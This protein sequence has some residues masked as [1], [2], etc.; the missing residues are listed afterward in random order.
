MRAIQRRTRH[1]RPGAP[2]TA[3]DARRRVQTVH[4]GIFGLSQTDDE[5][6]EIAARVARA[7]LQRLQGKVERRGLG[8]LDKVRSRASRRP[9]SGAPL[10]A[11]TA[12]KDSRRRR[13][14][15]AQAARILVAS[16]FCHALRMAAYSAEDAFADDEYEARSTPPRGPRPCC[17]PRAGA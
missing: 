11:V 13:A 17:L 15:G 6:R 3:A 7:L 14:S 9:P 10:F 2:A 8:K 4:T 12:S 5:G 1:T 16:I